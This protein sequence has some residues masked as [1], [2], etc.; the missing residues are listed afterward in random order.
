M[1]CIILCLRLFDTFNHIGRRSS[2]RKPTTSSEENVKE[3]DALNRNQNDSMWNIGGTTYDKTTDV[4]ISSAA[5]NQIAELVPKELIAIDQKLQE[6]RRFAIYPKD[7][8]KLQYVSEDN[9]VTGVKIASPENTKKYLERLD[10]FV[11]PA[12]LENTYLKTLSQKNCAATHIEYDEGRD[13]YW[14][15]KYPEKNMVALFLKP[16]DLQKFDLFY[17]LKFIRNRSVFT[18]T[19]IKGFFGIVRDEKIVKISIMVQKGVKRRNVHLLNDDSDIVSHIQRTYSIY[20]D[21]KFEGEGSNI[22]ER[23]GDKC[24]FVDF[25]GNKL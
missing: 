6:H 14:V 7:N 20:F 15:A 23:E 22:Y 4:N 2:S 11:V 12:S 16:Q 19:K 5:V 18:K 8:T 24:I 10:E 17:I 3:M 21:M 1:A 25:S 13:V 9:Y